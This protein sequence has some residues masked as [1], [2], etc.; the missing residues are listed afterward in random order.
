MKAIAL[1]VLL[2]SLIEDRH[3]AG[4]Y[5]VILVDDFTKVAVNLTLVELD[6]KSE[7]LVLR[8]S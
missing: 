6:V 2:K 1:L 7:E 8:G 5:D 3:E 4:D